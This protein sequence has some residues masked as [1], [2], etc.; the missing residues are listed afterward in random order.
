MKD[1]SADR[2]F[3][4]HEL[5]SVYIYVP[6]RSAGTTSGVAAAGIDSLNY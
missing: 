4:V 5:L 6:D 3:V 2:S 1:N